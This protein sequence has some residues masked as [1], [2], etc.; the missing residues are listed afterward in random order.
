MT[1]CNSVDCS[2]QVSPVHHQPL[3]LAQTHVH[4]VGDAIQPSQ[5]LWAPSSA[6]NLSQNQVIFQW[7]NYSS[8]LALQSELVFSKSEFSSGWDL[9]MVYC[10]FLLI[11]LAKK[12]K[13]KKN[14]KTKQNIFF[15]STGILSKE[16]KTEIR[17]L[18]KK[19]KTSFQYGLSWGAHVSFLH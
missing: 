8:E 12:K 13:K 18:G 10:H 4:Q 9:E 14:H 7:V 6:F 11:H 15:S 5:P 19:M 3:E 16:R 1:L 2:T 17:Q